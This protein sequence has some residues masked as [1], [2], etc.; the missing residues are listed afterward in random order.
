MADY[1]VIDS[2]FATRYMA[3]PIPK[4]KMPEQGIPANVVAQVIR[5]M[6]TL[7]ARPNLNLVS[8]GY[9]QTLRTALHLPF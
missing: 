3:E 4:L 5:D 8:L 2:T 1:N 7:D 6:R 9:K